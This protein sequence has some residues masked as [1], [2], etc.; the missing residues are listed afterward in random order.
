MNHSSM[1]RFVALTITLGGLVSGC[2]DTATTEPLPLVDHLSFSYSGA[3]SGAFDA[4]GDPQP[5]VDFVVPR[6]DYAGAVSYDASVSVPLAGTIS[7]IANDDAGAPYGNMFRLS[8]IPA[9]VGTYS[10]SNGVG[11]LLDLS[12]TWTSVNFGAQRS[13]ALTAGQITVVR[14]TGTHVLGTFSGTA[15]QINPAPS[16]PAPEITITNGQFDL[17][18]NDPA[19]VPV[20]CVLFGC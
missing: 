13:F 18:I 19:L 4:T 2:M 6:A 11:G 15:T 20:R 17:A 3:V 12:L 7:V 9:Q 5:A 14:Y 8:K 10:F 16:A 1:R